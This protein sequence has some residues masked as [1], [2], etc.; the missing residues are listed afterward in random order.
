MTESNLARG[1]PFAVG[2]LAVA[3][4]LAA[5]G[6]GSV[7]SPVAI[8]SGPAAVSSV[9][10]SAHAGGQQPSAELA[11]H[12]PA[13]GSE[14]A[15]GAHF[16]GEMKAYGSAALS[17]CMAKYGFKYA[18][19][20]A[21]VIAE[22]F[23]NNAQFPNLDWL[24]RNG[25][26]APPDLDVHEAGHMSATPPAGPGP[27]ES[28]DLNRCTTSIKNP[29]AGVDQV[30]RSIQEQWSNIWMRIQASQPVAAQLAEYST[31][32]Q[33][34]GVPATSASDFGRFMAWTTGM[35][36]QTKSEA[37]SAAFSRK[38]APIFV[39]CSEP[40]VMLQEKLQLE[41]K[42]TFVQEHYQQ[43]RQLITSAAHASAEARAQGAG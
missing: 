15:S 31:C 13:T 5:C 37:E 6:Q 12:V 41:A 32:M 29:F 26:L 40:T 22:H 42:K 33:N 10:G 30:G 38:W 3:V 27:A 4:V 2:S 1:I 23:W 35:Q 21:D 7:V 19:A 28:A 14:L 34:S 17:K 39:R 18:T 36:S 43:I 24:K 16:G 11:G 9:S 25:V 20:S 8:G